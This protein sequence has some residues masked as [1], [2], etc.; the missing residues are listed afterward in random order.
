[1]AAADGGELVAPGPTLLSD[2]QWQSMTRNFLQS[3]DA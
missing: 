3:P 2:E 1:M